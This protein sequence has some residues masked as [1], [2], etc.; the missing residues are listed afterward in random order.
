MVSVGN[1][2]PPPMRGRVTSGLG[3]TN[4][5]GQFAS[6]YAAAPLVA[7]VGLL[8]A[9]GLLGVTGALVAVLGARAAQ[10]ASEEQKG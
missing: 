6:P 5:L 9:F 2:A 10:R 3:V 4:Y 7:V 8:G 1:C